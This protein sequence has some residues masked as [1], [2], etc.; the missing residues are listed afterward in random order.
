MKQTTLDLC[1]Q[2]GVTLPTAEGADSLVART[3]I[4]GDTIAKLR[5]A[6]MAAIEN[7]LT[8]SHDAFLAWRHV[9][10][11]ARGEL[12]RLFGEELRASKQAMAADFARGVEL[13]RRIVDRSDARIRSCQRIGDG[14][15]VVRRVIVD[16]DDL[17][18]DSGLSEQRPHRC[19]EVGGFVS[20]RHQGADLSGR[21]RHVAGRP[22]QQTPCGTQ[23]ERDKQRLKNTDETKS[24]AQCKHEHTPKNWDFATLTRQNQGTAWNA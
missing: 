9:P 20:R 10:A 14:S 22:R 17:E 4:T 16:D 11:P 6:S 15:G 18:V 5:C 19:L 1:Q 3:P 24:C 7:A 8:Q 2:L 12:V 21:C 23:A 13:H